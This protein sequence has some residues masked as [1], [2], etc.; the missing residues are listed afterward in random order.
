MPGAIYSNAARYP[1]RQL[2]CLT[3]HTLGQWL[4]QWAHALLAQS[5][6]ALP[7]LTLSLPSM[8]TAQTAASS[9]KRSIAVSAPLVAAP[10]KKKTA[11]LPTRTSSTPVPC[12]AW[13][14]G[15][16]QS[17]DNDVSLAGAREVWQHR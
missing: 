11:P 9:S 7:T 3:V 13:G 2:P 4:P 10:K 8:Q 17:G 1:R 14:F 16:Y 6:P 12:V 5:P 15:G